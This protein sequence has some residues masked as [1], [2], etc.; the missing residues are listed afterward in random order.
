[1]LIIDKKE[2]IHIFRS[3]GAIFENNRT[4]FSFRRLVDFNSWGNYPALY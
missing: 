4:D 2:D 3:M 1:M